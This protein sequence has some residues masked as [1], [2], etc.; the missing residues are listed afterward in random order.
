[1]VLAISSP[2][3]RL[4][5][6]QYG[7]VRKEVDYIKEKYGIEIII[8]EEVDLFND[9]DDLAALTWACDYVVTIDNITT[10]IAGALGVDTY[11][12]LARNSYWFWG[13][14]QDKSLWFPSIKILRQD[15]L[16]NWNHPLSKIQI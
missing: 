15:V 2:K 4:V 1:M 12:L 7:D 14:N 8:L 9:I 10:S 3:V 5:C 16:G 13:I 6:L 11:L